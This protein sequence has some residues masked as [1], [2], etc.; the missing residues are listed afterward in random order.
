LN[1]SAHLINDFRKFFAIRP[2]PLH[3]RDSMIVP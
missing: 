2:R 1:R 3:I